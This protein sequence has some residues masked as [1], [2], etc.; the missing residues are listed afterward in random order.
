M[1]SSPRG[2]ALIIN[3]KTF[4]KSP[5]LE[6]RKGSEIDEIYLKSLLEQ[7]V[8]NVRGRP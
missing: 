6:F 2:E 8:F 4:S 3:N 1:D 5:N 7:L